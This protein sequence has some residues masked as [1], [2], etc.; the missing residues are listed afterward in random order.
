MTDSTFYLAS[1]LRVRWILNEPKP[2]P[3]WARGHALAD[4]EP[5]RN[6]QSVLEVRVG[7]SWRSFLTVAS[8]AFD[9]PLGI[10]YT[11]DEPITATVVFRAYPR[12]PALSPEK[13]APAQ[14]TPS[15]TQTPGTLLSADWSPPYHYGKYVVEMTDGSRDVGQYTRDGW[16]GLRHSAC[17]K[18]WVLDVGDAEA[19]LRACRQLSD[20]VK[21]R[22]ELESA[23][24]STTEQVE[25]L[26]KK[27]K[28]AEAQRDELQSGVLRLSVI[29]SA[30]RDIIQNNDLHWADKQSARGVR[31]QSLI[32]ALA[33]EPAPAKDGTTSAPGYV[34][35]I[36]NGIAI[37][38]SESWPFHPGTYS[39]I[40][41]DGSHRKAEYRFKGWDQD[42][43]EIKSW[44]L[45]EKRALSLLRECE[46]LAD[47]AEKLRQLPASS[48]PECFVNLL[49]AAEKWDKA[50][51]RGDLAGYERAKADLRRAIATCTLPSEQ[52]PTPT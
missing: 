36:I 51:D 46:V 47:E 6:N 19:L 52:N 42:V 14:P 32:D 38:L 9:T 50:V 8:L 41:T 2:A 7:D 22:G 10:D 33:L 39:I 37:S 12:D 3:T 18:S 30:A 11:S 43:R 20:K 24:A 13:D 26:R 44:V 15:V 21:G 40:C 17:V 29:A 34:P 31:E 27:L 4:Y 23:D 5:L 48:I 28:Q 16:I 35:A 1:D 45:D 25:E 49:G